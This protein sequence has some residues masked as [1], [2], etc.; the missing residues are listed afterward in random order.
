M[1][2]KLFLTGILS[3]TLV[4]GTF[5]AGCSTEEE[6]PTPGDPTFF[7]TGRRDLGIR[8]EIQSQSDTTDFLVTVNETATKPA[9]LTFQVKAFSTA[10][11][12]WSCVWHPD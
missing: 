7:V 4:F 11:R 12:L 1:K 3:L 8:L 5:F 10:A 9:D 6:T 2:T